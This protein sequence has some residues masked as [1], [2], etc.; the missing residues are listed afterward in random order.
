MAS[1]AG[2]ETVQAVADY[3]A[4]HGAEA[5]RDLLSG[6]RPPTAILY[7]NDVMAVAGLGVAQQMG[8]SVPSDVSIVSW[9]DSVLCAITHPALTAVGRDIS[10]IGSTAARLL[11]EVAA[12]QR[13]AHVREARAELVPRGST[14]P[15]PSVLAAG[16][17]GSG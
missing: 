17:V 15:A 11:R 7:D 10:G 3:T 9:D 16:C 5:T 13:P 2:I 8:I 4:E 6:S 12:G 14:G 1:A